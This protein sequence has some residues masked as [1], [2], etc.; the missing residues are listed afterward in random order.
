LEFDD[1]ILYNFFSDSD[2]DHQKW[3]LLES[4]SVEDMYLD[5]FEY[6]QRFFSKRNFGI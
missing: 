6:N 1:V 5:E 2:V 3:K 4:I